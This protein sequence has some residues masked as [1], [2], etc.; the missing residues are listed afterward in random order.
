MPTHGNPYAALDLTGK[1][2]V[3]TSAARG[4]GRACAEPMQARDAKVVIS[5]RS[6]SGGGLHI[7]VNNAGP[8]LNKL[9]TDTSVEE[10]RDILRV[11]A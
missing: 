3:V 4:I 8:T 6:E 1:G 7:L 11:N 9:N 10:F 5:D 2:A